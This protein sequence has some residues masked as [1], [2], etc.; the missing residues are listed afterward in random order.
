MGIQDP[1]ILIKTLPLSILWEL[2]FDSEVQIFLYFSMS[3]KPLYVVALS[4]CRNIE[5]L[6]RAQPWLYNMR[7]SGVISDETKGFLIKRL[8]S[9][10]R[11]LHDK[12]F[13]S[14]ILRNL[15]SDLFFKNSW[16]MYCFI[17]YLL[18]IQFIFVYL[19]SGLFLWI[20]VFLWVV[21]IKS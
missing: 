17:N 8:Y 5:K 2:Q 21:N 7:G 12:N 19:I 16:K 1:W 6:L 13:I 20:Y 14:N 3:P 11:W 4:N 18:F 10:E 9:A 15:K